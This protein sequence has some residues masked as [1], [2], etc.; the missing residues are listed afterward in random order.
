LPLAMAYFVGGLVYTLG[1]SGDVSKSIY[2]V[3]PQNLNDISTV[4]NSVRSVLSPTGMEVPDT[5][6]R[7]KDKGDKFRLTWNS[8]SRAIIFEQ[9]ESSGE[10]KITVKKRSALTKLMRIHRGEAGTLFKLTSIV[11][12]AG[13]IL[14]MLSGLFMAVN[15][16]V[17][18]N[19]VLT[20]MMSGIL[21]T[22]L[23]VAVEY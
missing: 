2:K 12:V 8:L 19:I 16:A 13:L 18:R 5:D 21:L 7:I 4:V 1:G 23:F 17:Y 20:A 9:N 11:L 22:V 10:A 3:S 15:I 6:P 14:T